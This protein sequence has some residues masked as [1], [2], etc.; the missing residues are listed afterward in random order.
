MDVAG[1]IRSSEPHQTSLPR[2]LFANTSTSPFAHRIKCTSDRMRAVG[3]LSRMSSLR[4][5]RSLRVGLDGR[6]GVE[7]PRDEGTTFILAYRKRPHKFPP[8]CQ[9]SIAINT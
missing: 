8:C 4:S 7:R 2:I 6:P 3:H 5:L 9:G 1:I